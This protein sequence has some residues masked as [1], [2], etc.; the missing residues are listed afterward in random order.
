VRLTPPYDNHSRLIRFA[1]ISSAVTPVATEGVVD[2]I[3]S[4]LLLLLLLVGWCSFLGA[5]PWFRFDGL[6][7]CRCLSDDCNSG[8]DVLPCFPFGRG[9]VSSFFVGTDE[10]FVMLV[11]VRNRFLVWWVGNRL[12]SMILAYALSETWGDFIADVSSSFT[13]VVNTGFPT[14]RFLP[15]VSCLPPGTSREQQLYRAIMTVALLRT[16]III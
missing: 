3:G 14:G 15:V 10:N 6:S 12:Q 4:L 9:F 5:S 8:S 1:V 7:D 11:D 16:R 13:L 2:A